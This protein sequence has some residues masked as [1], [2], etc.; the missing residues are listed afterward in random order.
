MEYLRVKATVIS[1]RLWIYLCPLNIPTQVTHASD[2][3]GATTF[4]CWWQLAVVFHDVAGLG[5]GVGG[6]WAK[7]LLGLWLW[8]IMVTPLATHPSLEALS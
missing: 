1:I 3:V 7:A 4:S 2:L 5:L 6:Y 8:L